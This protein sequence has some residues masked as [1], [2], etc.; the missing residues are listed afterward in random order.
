M[1]KSQVFIIESLSFED[2]KKKRMEGYVLQDMLRLSG[3]RE[4]KYFY[5]RTKQEL[6]SILDIFD[7]SN[8]RYL[9]FSCHG[10]KKGVG[11]T[12]DDISDDEFAKILNFYVD[13]KRIFFSACG[14][15]H[16]KLALKLFRSTD[17]YSIIG[18][19][20]DISFSCAAAFWLAFYNR[21]FDKS[22]RM[23]HEGMRHKDIYELLKSLSKIFN[24]DFMYY[25]RDS[26][27]KSGMTY[28][29]IIGNVTDSDE[30]TNTNEK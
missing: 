29:K 8:F 2:E 10:S 9:H 21:I 12:L 23:G 20:D 18:P 28:R 30:L 19:C 13:K 1:S 4:T 7:K 15:P 27:K 14:L 25:R 5:V 11:F 26:K 17:L 24:Q 16:K 3:K 22:E 6:V